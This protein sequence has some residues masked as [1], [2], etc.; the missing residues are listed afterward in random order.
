MKRRRPS[1]SVEMPADLRLFDA[2]AWGGDQ[3]AWRDAGYAWGEANGL[4][5]PQV[6]KKQFEY[7]RA[8]AVLAYR[9]QG[10]Q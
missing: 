7:R 5:R 3:Q 8:A 1:D 10:G 6:V 4:S 9:E 2:E